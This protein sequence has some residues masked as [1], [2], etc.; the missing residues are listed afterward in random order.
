MSTL[1]TELAPGTTVLVKGSH[2]MHM[3]RVVDRIAAPEEE[4]KMMEGN[5]CC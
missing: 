4:G 2:F 3:E 5:A 1:L